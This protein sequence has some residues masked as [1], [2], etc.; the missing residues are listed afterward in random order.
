V[1][2]DWPLLHQLLGGAIMI[3]GIAIP[4]LPRPASSR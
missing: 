2:G 4:L 1:L 3:G